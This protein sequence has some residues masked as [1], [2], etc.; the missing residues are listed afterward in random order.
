MNRARHDKRNKVWL[1]QEKQ[2]KLICA[3]CKIRGDSPVLEYCMNT[4]IYSQPKC[5]LAWTAD[6][7]ADSWHKK[8]LPLSLTSLQQPPWSYGTS[9]HRQLHLSNTATRDRTESITIQI[10]D[11][12]PLAWQHRT[13]QV[14]TLC[15]TSIKYHIVR[16]VCGSY[17]M[18]FVI[19]SKAC[20]F[21]VCGFIVCSL[22]T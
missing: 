8:V 21:I 14:Q 7:Q 11:T 3:I 19:K 1:A 15:I 17:T 6:H 12:I 20:G 2:T 5:E 16:N 10:Q 9:T 13:K 22:L 18:R 4:H